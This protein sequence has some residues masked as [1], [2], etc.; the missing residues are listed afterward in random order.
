MAPTLIRPRPL[1][2]QI[3][4]G[5]AVIAV[6]AKDAKIKRTHVAKFLYGTIVIGA[7]LLRYESI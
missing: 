4:A 2:P 1:S 6:I 3:S 5:P 7:A